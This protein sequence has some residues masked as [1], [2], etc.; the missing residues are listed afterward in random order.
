MKPPITI[1]LALALFCATSCEKDTIPG[2]PMP[3]DYTLQTIPSIDEV[4]PADLLAAMGPY[5][6]FGDN[7]PSIETCFFADSLRLTRFL[8]NIDIDPASTYTMVDSQY[9]KN[10]FSYQFCGQ[11]RGVIDTFRYERAFGDIAYGLG[12]FLFENATVT[13]SV[14]IMGNNNDF[15]IYF[16]QSCKRRMEPDE[17][18]SNYISDY[19]IERIEKII[20]TG[21]VTSEGISNFRMGMRV[22]SYSYDSPR[23][24]EYGKMPQRHD[25][26]LYD[27]PKIMEYCDPNQNRQVES[28]HTKP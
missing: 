23:I 20:M 7:P 15:T 1:L 28:K 9:F 6:H 27:Y 18:L 10:R 26:F 24:G 5:L 2:Q 8:H 22:E 13:D 4:M 19:D 14:F 21:S 16:K 3:L 25:I 12:Y 17:S 11:H